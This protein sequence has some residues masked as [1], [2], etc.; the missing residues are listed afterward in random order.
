MFVKAKKIKWT[1]EIEESGETI[2]I[3]AENFESEGT[4]AEITK[5]FYSMGEADE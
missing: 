5:F 2:V 1:I 4:A 3:E